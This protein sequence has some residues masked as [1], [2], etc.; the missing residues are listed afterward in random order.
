MA[1]EDTTPVESKETADVK[2]EDLNTRNK[3]KRFLPATGQVVTAKT[4]AE[5]TS[6]AKKESK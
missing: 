3:N 6:K 5:A 4:A 1:K 2:T